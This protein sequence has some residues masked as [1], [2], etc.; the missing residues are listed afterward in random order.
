[1][2][3]AWSMMGAKSP[4]ALMPETLTRVPATGGCVG[5]TVPCGTAANMLPV[6]SCRKIAMRRESSWAS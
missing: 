3:L 1:M 4:G 5:H 2:I 6:L